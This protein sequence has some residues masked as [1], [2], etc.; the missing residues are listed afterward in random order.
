MALGLAVVVLEAQQVAAVLFTQVAL[1][2]AV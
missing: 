2:E 1:P